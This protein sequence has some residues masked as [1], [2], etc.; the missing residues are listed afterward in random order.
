LFA[1]RMK[2]LPRRMAV[3]M[4]IIDG[5]DRIDQVPRNESRA[6][7]RGS[8]RTGAKLHNTDIPASTITV[9]MAGHSLAAAKRLRKELQV[10]KKS[11]DDKDI[12]LAVDPDNLL[13]WRAW[14]K[15]P[16]DTPY[17]SGVFELAI[18]C[19]TEYPL[20]PPQI[21]FVTK[22]FHPNVHFRT[23]TSSCSRPCKG[24]WR[25][26]HERSMPSCPLGRHKWRRPSDRPEMLLAHIT[27]STFSSSFSSF[28]R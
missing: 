5:C 27:S 20:A 17:Q 16:I 21:K 25:R 19:S 12:M 9:I 23:G 1:G 4:M 13:K 3:L 2:A 24:P 18:R 7:M 8:V 14:I 15:G 28:T 22:I 26:P 6:H 10:L 11:E